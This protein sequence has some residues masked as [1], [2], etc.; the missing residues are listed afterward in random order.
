M[1]G[2]PRNDQKRLTSAVDK[3]FPSFDDFR[4]SAPE[5]FEREMN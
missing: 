5:Y 3:Q 2:L 1:T 4:K